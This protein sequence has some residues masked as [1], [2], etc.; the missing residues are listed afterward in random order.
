MRLLKKEYSLS[1]EQQ[2]KELWI[3]AYM[4]VF[5]IEP[6]H[7]RLVPSPCM[8]LLPRA[9]TSAIVWDVLLMHFADYDSAE[10]ASNPNFAA[11]G[12]YLM[13]RISEN[14]TTAIPL[15]NYIA[16]EEALNRDHNAEVERVRDNYRT[17]EAQQIEENHTQ[18]DAEILEID[19]RYDARQRQLYWEFRSAFASSQQSESSNHTPPREGVGTIPRNSDTLSYLSSLTSTNEGHIF[20]SNLPSG[21][22]AGYLS[23]TTAALPVSSESNLDPGRGWEPTA[24]SNLH[25]DIFLSGPVSTNAYDIGNEAFLE[26]ASRQRLVPTPATDSRNVTVTTDV[27]RTP[28]NDA[29]EASEAPLPLLN[30][31]RDLLGSHSGSPR[32]A[33]YG[34][35]YVHCGSCDKICYPG[36]ELCDSCNDGLNMPFF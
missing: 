35:W 8:S 18:R 36:Q 21:Q 22:P 13:H 34:S 31:A 26:V 6:Q 33:V 15:M 32:D 25:D 17:L 24:D 3:D 12:R 1:D 7:R 10:L 19:N 5:D 30:N 11:F 4:E 20:P 14:P 9:I 27:L 23:P 2:S 16:V 29:M 28:V